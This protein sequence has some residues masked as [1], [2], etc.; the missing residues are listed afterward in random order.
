[1]LRC[2]LTV[3][4]KG[5][6]S[7]W[8]LWM[9]LFAWFSC[10]GDR[11]ASGQGNEKFDGPAELPRT[12]LR[13]ALSDTPAPGNTHVIRQ[14]D[15][16][17]A[18]IDGAKCGDTLKLQAGATFQG[19]FRLPAKPC[20]DAHWIVIRTSAMDDSLPPEGTRINPCYSGVAALPGRPDFRCSTLKPAT[21]KIEFNGKNG[22]GPLMFQAGANHY[23]LLGLEITRSE[24]TGT[25]VGALVSVQEARAEDTAN[26][27][28][29]D[30][31]WLHGNAQDETGRGVHLNGTTYFAVIDSYFSDFHC[32][33]VTG[34]CTDAQAIAG[35]SGSLP[36]GPYK[37][38]NN[39]L[40]GSGEN[41]LFGG[42]P[43]TTTPADIEIR[44]NH[45]FKPLIWK[46]GQPGFVS[47]FSGQPFI[48][49]NHFELKNAQ[50]VLF[51]GNVLENS[52]GGFSQSG[53]SILLTPKNQAN[54]CPDC[55]VTDV[56][57]RYNRISHVGSALQ[58]ANALS[59]A[60]G[61]AMAGER[62]SIHDL[63]VDDIN[64]LNYKGFGSFALIASIIPQLKDVR[65][66][67]VTAFP[68]RVLISI[69]NPNNNP[70]IE[71]LSVTNS[72][73][74]AT[75][76]Q[77]SSAGGGPGNCAF[78]AEQLQP[79]GVLRNCVVNPVFSHNAI[80]GGT[81]K[82]PAGNMLLKEGE[83]AQFLDRGQS[84]NIGRSARVRVGND[85]KNIGADFEA[86]ERATQGVL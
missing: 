36:G 79:D 62:Y 25:P 42:G 43:G 86:V 19:R 39:F 29:I 78:R 72:I 38:L 60:K 65:I 21:A 13:S 80:V 24:G 3:P 31:V 41:I 70:K 5:S 27:I 55:R 16:L 58:I 22:S 37:I 15:D 74:G 17:Q 45:L 52:W 50:R 75:R 2:R 20:D 83:E 12:F 49:K 84:R 61:S 33:A 28:V 23:R 9:A 40:E 63:M 53:F 71:N 7:Y 81:G 8:C 73:F 6:A 68:T 76:R 34:S 51:E 66:D 44:R 47:G 77:I 32:I 10:F 54:K 14:T 69:Q 82:W 30:R 4:T 18:A 46:R 26:H 56:T 59:G 48:V 67:H 35:G 64:D 1:M 85:G 11:D 57:I